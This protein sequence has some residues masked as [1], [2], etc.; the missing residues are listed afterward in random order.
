MKGSLPWWLGGPRLCLQCRRPGFDP[1]VGK[2]PWR[3]T[4]QPTPMFLPSELHGQRSPAG[5]SSGGCKESDTPE[6]LT[7]LVGEEKLRSGG[8]PVPRGARVAGPRAPRSGF[9][10][11]AQ[12]SA[13]SFSTC[14]A[15]A[16]PSHGVWSPPGPGTE[17]VPPASAGGSLT[18]GPAGS[19]RGFCVFQQPGRFRVT[20]RK[21]GPVGRGVVAPSP[22][23][24]HRVRPLAPREHPAGPC[25]VLCTHPQ[26][27]FP[28]HPVTPA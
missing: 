6:G 9:S 14:G 19:P 18:P 5:Y 28:S 27:K 1:W 26:K 7:H 12:T 15:Q 8:Q 20:G 13:S 3:R 2:I 17:P 24:L 10:R 11:G 23:C 4:W 22:C 25:V 16:G 21:T